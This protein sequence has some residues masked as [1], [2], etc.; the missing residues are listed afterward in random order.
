[1]VATVCLLLAVLVSDA[2]LAQAQAPFEAELLALETTLFEAITN[3]DRQALERLIA[4]D[5]VLRGSP[6]IPRETWIDN[7]VGLCWGQSTLDAVEVRGAGDTAVVSFE[8]MFDQDPV[9]CQRATLRSLVTDVW[10]RRDGVWQL[11]LRHSGSPGLGQGVAAQFGLVPQLPPVFELRGELSMVA[12]GGNAS[13]RTLGLSADATHRGRR[14]TTTGGIAFVRSE[15]EGVQNARS[16]LAQGR[17]GWR[18]TPRVEGFGRGEYLRDLF[19]GISHRGTAEGGLSYA[20]RGAPHAIRLDASAG[21]TSETRVVDGRQFASA[22]GAARYRFTRPPVSEFLVESSLTADLQRSS[23][24]RSSAGAS[25]IVAVNQVMS[26]RVGYALRY[27]HEPVPGFE[28]TDTRA[29][30]AL[31]LGYAR[32]APT[33]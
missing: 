27:L 14:A 24:W 8:L 31:V 5:Y 26:A 4:P 6:D 11:A 9:T 29:F 28:R 10:R 23:N 18:L 22:T 33:P 12:T 20:P 2:R 32:R 19:A 25:L 13:T 17:Q 3:R 15:S 7:A 1:M 21:M 30:A 16:L